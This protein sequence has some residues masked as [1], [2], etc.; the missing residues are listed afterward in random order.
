MTPTAPIYYLKRKAKKLARKD[1]IPLNA[2]LDSI[3]RDEGFQA[4]SHLAAAA[5][6]KDIAREMF[7]ELS[8]GDMVLLGARPGQGKTLFALKLA[9]AALQADWH[10]H[11]FTLEDH[12]QT[13]DNRLSDL[14]IAATPAL[15]V[16]T[17]E[18][19]CADYILEQTGQT[20]SFIV[21]DYL[22]MLDRNRS[23][24]DL[25]E[26]LTALKQSAK[27]IGHIIVMI[28]QISRSFE[29]AQRALPGLADIRQINPTDL[30]VFTHACFMSA[31]CAELTKL[32]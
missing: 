21:V 19:I 29:D 26:Q 30:S 7:R 28:S 10:S 31:G 6:E 14:G 9:Q 16:D 23:L 22:Q 32:N 13:V 27:M 5:P 18:E 24:P 4:W 20:P 8:V 15:T 2:A 11:I 1:G 12:A 25:S 3:A 17:S